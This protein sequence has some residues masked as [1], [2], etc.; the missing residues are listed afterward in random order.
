MG[1]PLEKAIRRLS[2][3]GVEPAVFVS[4]APRRPE[5]VGALRVVRVQEGG[6]RL[7]ACAFVDGLEEEKV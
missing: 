6:A 3:E 7:T 2:A 1:L 5:G 4:R